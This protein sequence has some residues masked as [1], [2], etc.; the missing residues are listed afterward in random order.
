MKPKKRWDSIISRS[1]G[2][3][4]TIE[5]GRNVPER[6]VPRED[7]QTL[8]L[9]GDSAEAIGR[10]EPVF[11]T[12]SRLAL[13]KNSPGCRFQPL[14]PL[15]FLP[16]WFPPRKYYLFATEMCYANSGCDPYPGPRWLTDIARGFTCTDAVFR[17][18]IE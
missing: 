15:G 17:I 14:A 9:I 7:P 18:K 1:K 11:Q 4:P 10:L 2:H 5:G 6:L 16:S 3:R 12:L 13:A 8:K